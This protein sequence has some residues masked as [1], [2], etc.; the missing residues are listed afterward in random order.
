MSDKP[1]FETVTDCE[2]AIKKLG[3]KRDLTRE[4]RE[5][6]SQEFQNLLNKYRSM[7]G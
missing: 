7:L 1:Y 5:Q 2:K 4:E 6:I 3:I